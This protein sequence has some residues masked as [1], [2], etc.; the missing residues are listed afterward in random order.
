[1][2]QSVSPAAISWKVAQLAPAPHT[3]L[4]LFRT[5]TQFFQVEPLLSVTFKYLTVI[6]APPKLSVLSAKPAANSKL[7]IPANPHPLPACFSVV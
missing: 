1:M 5:T 3:V 6:A 7:I 4:L 2:P